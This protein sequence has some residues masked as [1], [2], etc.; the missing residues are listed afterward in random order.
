[1]HLKLSYKNWDFGLN[2]HGSVGNYVF[3]D[4]QGANSSTFVDLNVGSLPNCLES[5]KKF[6]FELANS[7]EQYYSDMFLENASFFRLD[8]VNLG[9]TFRSI[10]N[11]KNANL[12]LGFTAQNLFVLTQYSGIDPELPGVNGID[13][14]I[15]PRPR[16]YSFR[17]NFNF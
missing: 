12:R 10:G 9:Y 3:N 7:T 1:M 6:G 15:W 4:L 11:W 2:G 13:G 14:S 16:T 17:V 5:V 8:D